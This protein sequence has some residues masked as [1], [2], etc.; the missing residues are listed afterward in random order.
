LCLELRKKV[1][2]ETAAKEALQAVYA[3]LQR[4]HDDLEE[5]TIAACQGAEGEGGQSGSSLVSHLGS[6]GDRVTERLK[7][8]LRLG[9]QKALG[10]ISTHYVVDFEHLATGYIVPTAMMTLR[11][12]LWSRLTQ[13]LKVLPPPWPGSSKATYSPTPQTTKRGGATRGAAATCR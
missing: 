3:S 5:A 13:V 1:S 9:I 2:E 12:R 6:L 7:G 4:D 10:V 11:S 8:A